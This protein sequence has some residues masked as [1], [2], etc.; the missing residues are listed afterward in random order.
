VI[1]DNYAA[2]SSSRVRGSASLPR[3]SKDESSLNMASPT[4]NENGQ[5]RKSKQQS[6]RTALSTRGRQ[7][8]L[9]GKVIKLNRN[10]GG[11]PIRSQTA[12][13][14]DN[15]SSADNPNV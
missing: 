13:M 10:V 7:N 9:H 8:Q 2:R 14:F 11:L 5:A 12:D 1:S 15:S 4:H 6:S 3:K